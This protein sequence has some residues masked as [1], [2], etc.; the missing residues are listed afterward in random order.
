LNGEYGYGNDENFWGLI[1][2]AGLVAGSIT[3][4]RVGSTQVVVATCRSFDLDFPQI[5]RKITRWIAAVTVQYGSVSR[6]CPALN[7]LSPS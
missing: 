2:P 5:G 7:P 6:S 4:I 1:D 3:I